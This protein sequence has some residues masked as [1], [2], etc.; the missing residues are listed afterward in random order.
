[1][2]SSEREKFVGAIS[3]N[4]KS[5]IISVPLFL[6]LYRLWSIQVE[7]SSQIHLTVGHSTAKDGDSIQSQRSIGLADSVRN[8]FSHLIPAL[9]ARA[10]NGAITE[11]VFCASLRSC[12]VI[13]SHRDVRC[14]WL[15]ILTT[16]GYLRDGDVASRE[17]FISTTVVS[18]E[19]LM[20]SFKPEGL[21][22]LDKA[23]NNTNRDYNQKRA[24]SD[25]VIG[26]I[27]RDV[28]SPLLRKSVAHQPSSFVIGSNQL[29]PFSG[30]IDSVPPL[31]YQ[32]SSLLSRNTAW[33]T[34]EGSSV[35]NTQRRVFLHLAAMQSAERSK[36]VAALTAATGGLILKN[37]NLFDALSKA[38]IR[39]RPGEREQFWSDSLSA[40]RS[41]SVECRAGPCDATVG[42]FLRWIQFDDVSQ[43]ETI[44]HVPVNSYH[45]DETP[46]Q[47]N[48]GTNAVPVYLTP[49]IE[50]D[51]N[52]RDWD[53]SISEGSPDSL[54]ERSQPSDR[55]IRE[56]QSHLANPLC[57]SRADY[58]SG[59]LDNYNGGGRLAHA[60]DREYT[61][62]IRPSTA[63]P[64]SKLFQSHGDA[65]PQR[66]TSS[67][68]SGRRQV[69]GQYGGRQLHGDSVSSLFGHGNT[70]A[71]EVP[72][73]RSKGSRRM[74]QDIHADLRIDSAD[75]KPELPCITYTVNSKV[76]LIN[77]LQSK[78][79]LLAVTFRGMMNE[80]R[81]KSGGRGVS[82]A[83]LARALVREP[84]MVATT[85]E[86]ALCLTCDIMKLDS[87]SDAA[88]TTISYSDVLRYL[89]ENRH[90]YVVSHEDTSSS[91]SSSH[92]K[93]SSSA[94]GYS[95]PRPRTQDQT[96][97]TDEGDVDYIYASLQ[98]DEVRKLESSILLKLT[99]S[100]DIRNDRIRLLALTPMLRMR[101]R[102]QRS[103]GDTSS[104][105]PS[106]CLTPH[107]MIRLLQSVDIYL[108]VDEG[109]LIASSCNPERVSSA[110]S[111]QGIGAPLSAVIRYLADLVSR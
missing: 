87:T 61:A 33:P 13:L 4:P 66:V 55:D 96:L 18:L 32:H 72:S 107:E 70:F 65:C 49:Q 34:D 53:D 110:S 37:V 54:T 84:L 47:V 79:A 19:D 40:C 69:H 75:R 48:S 59:H 7:D 28:P 101:L 14:L 104:W 57:R 60:V 90:R 68:P 64:A 30:A 51:Y 45:V 98:A 88:R 27:Q 52:H 17:N 8:S 81:T 6:S 44:S 21:E 80:C 5:L 76:P 93:S 82:C 78:V 102:K 74:Y 111:M 89:G 10:R 92:S 9:T 109:N 12:G 83:D 26:A 22:F 63:P 38:G 31:R 23:V 56:E 1:M 42:D 24:S 97:M 105:D 85:P 3:R 58:A 73:V 15:Q 29:H 62:P 39:L 91:S 20:T 103:Q 108:S 16:N 86:N 43:V 106:D 41:F 95:I 35:S 36:F 50:L 100:K 25:S 99:Q 11:T 2:S 71:T 46:A 77:E 67:T 94:A